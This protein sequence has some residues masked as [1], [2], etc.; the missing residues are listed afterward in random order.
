M[1]EIDRDGYR[2]TETDKTLIR[3]T[4][5]ARSNIGAV[6]FD[7]RVLVDMVRSHREITEVLGKGWSST[8]WPLPTR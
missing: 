2:L 6:H 4:G 8:K 5:H 7:G 3:G 1:A